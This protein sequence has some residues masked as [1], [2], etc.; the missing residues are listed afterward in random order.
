MPNS[1]KYSTSTESNAL[2]VNNFYIGVG[3][4]SKGPTDVTGY[5]NGITPPPGGYTIYL[6]KE[7]Q[8]PSIYRP[9]NNTEL[10]ILTNI[11]A[12]SNYT[13]TT[14]CFDYFESQEDK[15]IVNIDYPIIITD[16]P[17]LNLDAGFLP[18][19]MRSGTLWRDISGNENNGTLINDPTF[20]SDNGGSIVFDG[21]NDYVEVVSEG[22]DPF[23]LI[24]TGDFTIN[25]FASNTGISDSR[26]LISNYD[27]NTGIQIGMDSFSSSFVAY[28]GDD[29]K[30]VASY[31]IPS[32]G[33]Y[34][35][36]SITRTS[37]LIR[38]YVDSV[39]VG[40]AINKTASISSSNILIGKGY[41]NEPWKGNIVLAQIY[42]KSLSVE[43]IQNNYNSFFNN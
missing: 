38:L 9:A 18:S 2:K 5:W 20:N 28:V 26:W 35:F 30:I 41:E 23:T 43:D 13:T 4:V 1:I 32:D 40:S 31:S 39:E 21:V 27:N 24:G 34:H 11:I 8:G 25:I 29:E 3:D 33:S 37:G 16:G 42:N 12:G 36:Y 19:Y 10:I 17:I 14:Q 22:T 6:N 7:F 15:F